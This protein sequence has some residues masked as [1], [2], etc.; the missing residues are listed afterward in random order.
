MDGGASYS[1]M[2]FAEA[3]ELGLARPLLR[4]VRHRGPAADAGQQWRRAYCSRK[5]R[6]TG[7]GS[8]PPFRGQAVHQIQMGIPSRD[9]SGWSSTCAC[10]VVVL[11]EKCGGHAARG[12]EPNRRARGARPAHR[13]AVARRRPPTGLGSGLVWGHTVDEHLHL[14]MLLHSATDC[15]CMRASRAHG[16]GWAGCSIGVMTALVLG[17]SPSKMESV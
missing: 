12:M 7:A 16:G 13:L 2:L 10:A 1:A 9:R 6:G 15:T 4:P 17:R 11:E 5:D 8:P 3:W 14:P